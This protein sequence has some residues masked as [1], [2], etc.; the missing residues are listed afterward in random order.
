MAGGVLAS[1][2]PLLMGLG[3]LGPAFTAVKSAF[4]ALN[5]TLLTN[6]FFLLAIALITIGTL[7]FFHREKV[8]KALT[9]AW[10]F[11]KD[12]AEKVWGAI[13]G[14][15]KKWWPLL[16]VI[17]TG[18][19]G[20][21]VVA[22]VKHW[23][24]IKETTVAVFDAVVGFFKDLP[25]RIVAG[26]DAGIGAVLG[27]FGALKDKIL[28]AIGNT[29]TALFDTGKDFIT[30][31]FYGY[32]TAILAVWAWYGALGLKLIDAIGDAGAILFGVGKAIITGLWD[33]MKAVW[34]EMKGWLGSVGGWITDLKGPL[35]TDVKLLIPQG[36]AIMEGLADGMKLGFGK[37]VSPLL[38][39]MTAGIG[40]TPTRAGPMRGPVTL[41]PINL[42]LTVELDNQVIYE[43]IV[44][45][46]KSAGE[47]AT[48]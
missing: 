9:A 11:V 38:S 36:L 41:P 46:N 35:S 14:F 24:K 34:E 48:G 44:D 8:L 15:F 27:W 10:E 26:V 17:M 6:P 16:L 40:T 2:G 4:M 30:G 21:V 43:A 19:I 1:I 28:G 47:L 29:A 12:T 23:D 7:I 18:G 3:Q 32:K 39:D 13:L 45:M 37:T 5:T 20:L 31:L 42:A 33:G 22:I 25:G